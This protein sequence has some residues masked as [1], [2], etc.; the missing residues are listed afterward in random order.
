MANFNNQLDRMRNL[1]SYGRVDENATKS[2]NI[3]YSVKGADGKVYGIIREN[4]K[5]YIKYT[6]EG[7]ESLVE[8]YEY[9]G[10]WCNKKNHEYN[11]YTNA[12]KQLEMKLMSLNEAYN[13]NNDVK[14][15]DPYKKNDLVIEATDNMKKEI[16]R[17]R[18]IMA[19]TSSILSEGNTISMKNTGV[20]EAPKTEKFNGDAGEPF[21]EKAEAQLDKD[22]NGKSNNPEDE[23]TPFEEDGEVTDADMESDKAPKCNGECDGLENAE[24]VPDNAIAN[25][26]PKGGKEV[27]MNEGCHTEEEIIDEEFE[28]IVGIDDEEGDIQLDDEIANILGDD[29]DEESGFPTSYDL[30][31]EEDIEPEM[32]GEDEEMFGESKLNKLVNSITE[33]VTNKIIAE[34]GFDKD[35]NIINALRKEERALVARFRAMRGA[36]YSEEAANELKADIEELASRIE[37]S[38]IND[39]A[40]TDLLEDTK[41]GLLY[42]L[43]DMMYHKSKGDLSFDDE[44]LDYR[45][46]YEED[47]EP[48]M[49]EDEFM[50]DVKAMGSDAFAFE[51][52][53]KEEKT[54]LH[55]FGKHPGYRKKPM[56]LP[57]DTE[58]A[59]KDC[60][61][62]CDDS[63][64]GDKPF[65][66]KIGSSAPFDKQV[67]VITDAVMGQLKEMFAKDKKKR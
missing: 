9:I 57:A 52:T 63:V 37:A 21:E 41:W 34:R 12:V 38:E 25:E 40:K 13:Q 2:N 15:L 32:G 59:D 58:V 51:S 42:D 23:G 14:V 30:E 17:Q 18:E 64:K 24:Y 47:D 5:F 44:D 6:I 61:D 20:P 29:Y 48:D 8:S 60:R 11:S 28:D 16:A 27:K 43:K 46:E 3:E 35:R 66:Q 39:D 7:K 50:D 33:S 67:K 54:E 55:N 26:S 56:T 65:G 62:W 53:I 19:N 31:D 22:L 45:D 10:G 36:N 49:S 4:S 1:M